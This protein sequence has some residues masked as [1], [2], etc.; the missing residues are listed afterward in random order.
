MAALVTAYNTFAISMYKKL[1]EHNDANILFSPMSIGTV[2]TM[3]FPGTNG[4]TEFQM[5]NV[6]NFRKPSR[7]P[8][9][10]SD[11]IQIENVPQ[12]FE[13]FISNIKQTSN[14]Y[15]MKL[16]NRLFSEESFHIIQQYSQLIEKHFQAKIQAMNFS[17]EAE[18]SR[19]TINTWVEGE[20]DGI[21]K[22]ILPPDSISSL[23][24]LV[25]VNA[26][27]FK[28]NW[29]SKFPEKNTEQKPFRMSKSK[30]KQVQMMFQRNKFNLFYIEELE[31]KVLEL[32]YVN[33]QLSMIILLPDDI[34]DNTTG[35]EKLE[36]ELSYEKL[37]DWTNEEVM[38][39]TE[40]EIDLP[41]IHLEEK[42]D[43]KSYLTEM[44]LG[45]LFS[46]DKAD[47]TGISDK[48]NLC[49]S[50]IFHKA[51]VKVNEEGTEA[52]A[53]TAGVV[54][55]RMLPITVKFQADHPF[56]FMIRDNQTKAILFLGKFSS[57]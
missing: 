30:S 21:I 38:E 3:L 51:F 54:T 55:V 22:E 52:T 42:Y 31:T 1:I 50:E 34:K 28:G 29:E 25:L 49:V 35:L 13:E 24:K 43:L 14:S 15:S 40:V 18:R 5:A 56:L 41:R 27:Y 44:G 19:K 8:S 17:Q 26:I 33:T 39:N 9:K 10:T 6:L 37:K 7:K 23:T 2:L 20:T 12:V 57:P 11:A 47:L 36:N 48:G 4:N 46:E 45:D 16:A 53:A 32:P